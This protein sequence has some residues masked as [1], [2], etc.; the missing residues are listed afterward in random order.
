MD[1]GCYEV[2]N[3]FIDTILHAVNVEYVH[4]GLIVM[5]TNLSGCVCTLTIMHAKG[6]N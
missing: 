2:H 4:E 3:N 6:F 1:M 5:C